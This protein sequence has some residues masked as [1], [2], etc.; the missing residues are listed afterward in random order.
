MRSHAS[1]VLAGCCA[2]LAV[3]CA[4]DP[5][6]EQVASA[7]ARQCKLVT[8]YS[9]H[10]ALRQREQDPATLPEGRH[11]QAAGTAAKLEANPRVLGT[12]PGAGT[13][14]DALHDCS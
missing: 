6:G 2:M 9:Y 14:H 10:D 8:V 4:T 12:P 7:P 13:M 5:S 1:L 3:G 11:V